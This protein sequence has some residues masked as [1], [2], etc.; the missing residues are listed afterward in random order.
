MNDSYITLIGSVDS[1]KSNT[2]S[3]FTTRL[4]YP[5]KLRKDH[6]LIGLTDIVLPRSMQNMGTGSSYR[7]DFY[8][9]NSITVKVPRAHYDDA[10]KLALILN[11]NNL[12]PVDNPDPKMYTKPT[13][14]FFEL[15]ELTNLFTLK[16]EN[17][18]VDQVIMNKS[19]A[20]FLGFKQTIFKKTA[21]ALHRVDFFNQK[22]VV[23]IYCDL[24]TP[25]IV[26]D[27]RVQ[28]LQTCPVTVNYGEMMRHTFNPVRYLQP[29]Y[30][31]VDTIYIE[32]MDEQGNPIDFSW[33][34][35]VL[36]LHIKSQ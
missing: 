14:V 25:S 10:N 27:T 15:D 22:S 13:G 30:D 7:I 6:D 1:K 33:G 29:L 24:V 20:Y 9:F 35:V 36:T 2:T 34:S 21:T 32:I 4:P 12:A 26:G 31:S 28:L 11:K 16:I 23:Y 19:L 17:P 3:R 5:L 8:K 18:D